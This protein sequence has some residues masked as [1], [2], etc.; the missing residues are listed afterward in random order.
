MYAVQIKFE[1]HENYI[2]GYVRSYACYDIFDTA[3]M[4]IDPYIVMY[5]CFTDVIFCAL[6]SNEIYNINSFVCPEH[7]QV[8]EILHPIESGSTHGKE[9]EEGRDMTYLKSKMVTMYSVF[10]SFY[11]FVLLKIL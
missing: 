11:L 7:P 1:I 5:F 9:S 6:A 8:M 10:I 2:Y 3:F 4:F